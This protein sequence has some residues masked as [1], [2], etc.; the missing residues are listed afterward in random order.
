MDKISIVT[1]TFNCKKILEKT[2]KSIISQTYSNIEYIVIDGSS[3]DGTLD[4]L[5]KYKNN[6]DYFISEPDKGIFDAMNK[7][8]NVATGDWIIFMNAGDIFANEN[9]LSQIFNKDF[10]DTTVI[11]GKT[12]ALTNKGVKIAQNVTP[13]FKRKT[14]HKPMGI[15]HQSI[16]VSLKSPYNIHF[17]LEYKIAADYCMIKS[18]YDSGA[19]FHYV[20]MA[21]STV[22]TRDGLSAKN[23]KIQ[24]D[25]EAK[26]CGIYHTKRYKLYNLKMCLISFIKTILFK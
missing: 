26:I 10:H 15:N 24:R 18:L 23:R 8:I 6:I 2:I 7:A 22:E 17:N 4:I 19:R 9:I 3:K 5:E 12:N 13:F 14:F 21:I 16:F 25:E 11:Y 20:D 1:V